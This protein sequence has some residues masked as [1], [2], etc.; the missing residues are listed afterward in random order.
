MMIK[1]LLLSLA[2]IAEAGVL[3]YM[4]SRYSQLEQ[5]ILM[6]QGQF[7]SRYADLH[8]QWVQVGGGII[9]VMLILPFTLY[10]LIRTFKRL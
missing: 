8:A 3:F 5:D 1:R 7:L 10:F 4:Y 9:L 2:L 6:V